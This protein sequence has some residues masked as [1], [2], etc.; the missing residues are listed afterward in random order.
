M[1]KLALGIVSLAAGLSSILPAYAFPIA[2]LPIT[3]QSDVI[4]VRNYGHHGGH[5]WHGHGHY[6]H[7]YSRYNRGYGGYRGYDH[8]G[9]AGAIIGGLAAG[10][11]IGGV[12][13]S[14]SH[15]NGG[16]HAQSCANRYRTYRASDNTFQPNSG[17]R[18][19]CR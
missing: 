4:Q 10:A 18:V 11:I 1:N 6:N 7:G 12:L 15:Y 16:T 5:I 14:Q 9:N 13:A 8:D 19:Q 17:P 3:Q 2:E